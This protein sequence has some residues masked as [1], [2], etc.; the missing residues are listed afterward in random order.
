MLSYENRYRQEGCRWIFGVDEAGRGP[1]AG[2]VVAAAVWLRTD[3]FSSRIDD[4]KKLTA[5]QR[6]R[7][8]EE[9]SRCCVYGVGVVNERVID[10]LNIL[11]ATHRAMEQA[12]SELAAR[13]QVAD[14]SSVR[15]LVDGPIRLNSGFACTPII[16]GDA[17]SLSI[18]AASIVAK[19]LRDRIMDIYDRILPGY[20]FAKHRGYPTAHHRGALRTLGRS[21]VHRRSFAG[22]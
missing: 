16:G 18:A 19:V 8:F 11:V 22:V 17:A 14:A 12:V 21:F 15:L 6:T 7:A 4:S 1:L 10:R 3:R 13:L 20:G 2:P 5:G 9:I